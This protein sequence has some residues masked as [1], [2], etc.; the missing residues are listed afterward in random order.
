MA[1]LY[2]IAHRHQAAREMIVV[3]PQQGNGEEKV[4][5][6]VEHKRMLIRVLLLLRKE[7]HWVFTPVT[8]RV[9]MVRC[10]I[11]IVVAVAVALDW[12]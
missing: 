11:A 8:K 3:P 5:D 6:V 4:V 10:M 2:L 7:C 12:R 1:E 9:Q